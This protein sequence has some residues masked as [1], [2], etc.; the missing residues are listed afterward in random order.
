MEKVLTRLTILPAGCLALMLATGCG[1]SLANGTPVDA[2]N[3]FSLSKAEAQILTA[4]VWKWQTTSRYTS[5]LEINQDRTGG[6]RCN[7]DGKSVSGRFSFLK[8]DGEIVMTSPA[9]HGQGPDVVENLRFQGDNLLISGSEKGVAYTQTYVPIPE[10]P[11]ICQRIK[12]GE[13]PTFEEYLA[14]WDPEE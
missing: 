9:G 10:L 4:H 6:F 14:S 12:A 13:E 3:A 5:F 8:I 2:E 1:D 11:T 7:N